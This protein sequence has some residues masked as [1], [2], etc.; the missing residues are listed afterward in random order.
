MCYCLIPTDILQIVWNY[1]SHLGFELIWI[2]TFTA[3]SLFAAANALNVGRSVSVSVSD[4]RLHG[5]IKMFA[6]TCNRSHLRTHKPSHPLLLQRRF[7]INQ[8]SLINNA[9]TLQPVTLLQPF[10]EAAQARGPAAHALLYRNRQEQEQEQSHS[11]RPGLLKQRHRLCL[12][13][14]SKSV[15]DFFFF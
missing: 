13:V 12:G 14:K 6:Q 7:S 10:N 3:P 4:Y 1:Y 8:A 15:I 2:I 5:L 11:D 9:W